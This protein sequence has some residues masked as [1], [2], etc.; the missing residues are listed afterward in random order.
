MA[1]LSDAAR[2]DAARQRPEMQP[3]T[4]GLTLAVDPGLA[5]PF[6]IR[7]GAIVI[8]GRDRGAEAPLALTLRLAAETAGWLGR[9]PP[10][11]RI[12][13]ALLGAR[14]AAIAHGMMSEAERAAC[15]GI[16]PP[17]LLDMLGGDQPPAASPALATLTGQLLACQ[18]ESGAI[19]DADLAAAL[20]SAA[21]GQ[22]WRVA[23]PTESLL[24]T[25]GDERLRLVPETGLNRYGCSP[26][27]RPGAFTFASTTATS[28]S[29]GAF[30][31]VEALRRRLG[32][33]AAAG[34][35]EEDYGDAMA[36]VRGA[37]LGQCAPPLPHD[38][39][40]HINGTEAILTPSGTDGEFYALN[41]A[42][43]ADDRPLTNIVIAPQETASNVMAAAAGRH[44]NPTT[45]MGRHV[46]VG[47]PVDAAATAR[48]T[49]VTLAVRAENGDLLPSSVIDAAAVQA[50]EAAI[51]AGR[52]VLLHLLDTSKTG[53]IAPGIAA[54]R[55]LTRRFPGSIDV[56]V[57]ASQLRLSQRSVARYLGLGFMVI[58]TGS[59]FFTGPPFSGALLVPA[60][61]GERVGPGRPPLPQGYDAY[62]ERH[63]WPRSWGDYGP[64][65]GGEPN[66]GLLMRWWAALWE[67]AAFHAVPDAEARSILTT[68]LDAVRPVIAGSPVLRLLPCPPP[69]R[70]A[71]ERDDNRLERSGFSLL[72]ESPSTLLMRDGVT[73]GWD[74][75]P[76]ILTFALVPDPAAGPLDMA[77]THR[78]Y[79][80][81]N[82]DVAALLPA[83][84]GDEERRLAQ[85]CAHIG[86]PVLVGS[87][88]LCGLRLSAGA[89]L[90]S[91]ALT[92][93]VP[94]ATFLDAEITEAK[95]ILA[96]LELLLRHLAHLC[97]TAP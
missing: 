22:G 7:D 92:A 62:S 53:L 10:A 59:K 11:D 9:L 35:L 44:Y 60:A 89:R 79:G 4:A 88:G 3:V 42:L 34:R 24:T 37:I 31:H 77:T 1:S 41:L 49:L 2:L 66:L 76:T 74:A 72:S 8:A 67:M 6:L 61:I 18:G 70:V 82:R 23:A 14:A 86:Q 5:T 78:I 87:D 27:P 21:F 40:P 20:A 15:C 54:T 19:E 12:T 97:Q 57:D 96:K 26:R 16:L 65:R 32:A 25:G 91:G 39:G 17:G 45:A 43:A 84:A 94:V 69:D 50:V 48:T 68:F 58:V 47:E 75:L 30:A 55:A 29:D 33:A 13:A 80:W 85:L 83:T 90:V 46:A 95:L 56:V 93:G 73:P 51:A 28:I 63:C 52:R 36:T 71:L 38:N 81:L 64:P